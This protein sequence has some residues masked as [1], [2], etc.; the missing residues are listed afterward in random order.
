MRS[1]YTEINYVRA[2]VFRNKHFV[3][4]GSISRC[5][6]HTR[7][8]DSQPSRDTLADGVLRQGG[9]GES[10]A[11]RGPALARRKASPLI[12]TL[13]GGTPLEVPSILRCSHF[14]ATRDSIRLSLPVEHNLA[15]ASPSHVPT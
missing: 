9:S 6:T 13:V 8:C 4:D 2:R 1:I 3:F 7:C 11:M 14:I 15:M 5:T 10:Q 12:T